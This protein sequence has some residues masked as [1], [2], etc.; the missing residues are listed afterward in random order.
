M[1]VAL[2]AGRTVEETAV[3]QAAEEVAPMLFDD[4]ELLIVLSEAKSLSQAAEQLYMS[5]PGLSQK[6]ANIE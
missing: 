3:R 6:I 1:M 4:I 5:R 2:R